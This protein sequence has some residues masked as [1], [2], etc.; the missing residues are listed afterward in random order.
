MTG[1]KTD[2]EMGDMLGDAWFDELDLCGGSDAEL[3]NNVDLANNWLAK[4]GHTIR[5]NECRDYDETTAEF[6]WDVVASS[7]DLNT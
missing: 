6:E 1:W 2:A 3:D 4:N 5:V 7:R